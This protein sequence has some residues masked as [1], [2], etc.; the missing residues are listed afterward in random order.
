MANA[1]DVGRNFDPIRQSHARNLTQRRVWLLGRLRIDT[2]ANATLLR[3]TLE[4]RAGR[5][6]LDCLA[7]FANKL[8]YRRH[9]FLSFDEP[10]ANA[11]G[12]GLCV[13]HKA[14]KGVTCLFPELVASATCGIPR[15]IPLCP[16]VSAGELPC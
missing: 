6:V 16:A 14:Q 15:G 10:V 11:S 4:R 9:V 5:L 2:G 13:S 1:G 8:I 7:A 3:R 12:F